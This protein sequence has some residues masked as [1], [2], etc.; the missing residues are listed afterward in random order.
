M[1]IELG[2]PLGV[3]GLTAD[4]SGLKGD[5]WVGFGEEVDVEFFVS[6]GEEGGLFEVEVGEDEESVFL[7]G[8]LAEEGEDVA[9]SGGDDA[10]FGVGVKGGVEFE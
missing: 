5:A 4:F 10:K 2:A 1:V 9:G 7:L 6:V 3:V 8:V